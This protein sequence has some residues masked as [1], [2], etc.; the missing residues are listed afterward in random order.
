MTHLVET[1]DR[2]SAEKLAEIIGGDVTGCV[3]PVC[4]GEWRPNS[5]GTY[6]FWSDQEFEE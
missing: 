5:D 6:T 2:V 4:A 1:T 3:I